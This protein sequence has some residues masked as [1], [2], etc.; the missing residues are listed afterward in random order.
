MKKYILFII[1]GDS[2]FDYETATYKTAKKYSS[3]IMFETIPEILSFLIRTF[4]IGG[5][6]D[7][8]FYMIGEIKSKTLLYL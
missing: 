4:N 5:L 3:Q 1:D 8:N 6:S 2:S 7:Q